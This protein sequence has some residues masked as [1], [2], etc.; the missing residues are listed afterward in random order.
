MIRA[1]PPECLTP[2]GETGLHPLAL[3]RSG[4]ARGITTRKKDSVQAHQSEVAPSLPA[5]QAE[6]R[7][8]KGLSRG[9]TARD[10]PAA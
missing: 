10:N 8:E 1:Q 4:A 5:G 7:A 2:K 3:W 9:G 6:A